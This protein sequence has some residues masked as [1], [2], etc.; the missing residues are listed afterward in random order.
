MVPTILAF[1]GSF[2]FTPE[3]EAERKEIND[4][5]R[6]SGRFDAVLD[7]DA[8]TRDPEKPTFL[9]SGLDSGDHLHL[10]DSG[11]EALADSIDLSLFSDQ[12][13]PKERSTSPRADQGAAL[14]R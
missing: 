7:F 9:M 3:R 6:N 12:G 14:M 10:N 11:Y 5:I 1:E 8:A 2:H 4:W 13:R